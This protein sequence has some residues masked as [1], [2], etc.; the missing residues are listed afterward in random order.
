[1]IGYRNP[2]GYPDP[3]PY[4]AIRRTEGRAR[5]P[6]MPLVYICSAN[7]SDPGTNAERTRSFCRFALGQGRIPLAAALM[8][9]QFM[10]DCVPEE[11]ELAGPGGL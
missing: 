9:P 1:M 10:D 11:R 6:F 4:A 2:E 7:G 3:T 8:F 5:P